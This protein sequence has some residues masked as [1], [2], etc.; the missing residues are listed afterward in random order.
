[1]ARTRDASRTASLPLD[2]AK[3]NFLTL[4]LHKTKLKRRPRKPPDEFDSRLVVPSFFLL[5]ELPFGN[6]YCVINQA[7][8]ANALTFNIYI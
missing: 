8:F 6:N 4:C 3:V 5:A 2:L 1:M 7:A